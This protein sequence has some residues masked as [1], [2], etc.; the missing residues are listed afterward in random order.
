MKKKKT[1][2]AFRRTCKSSGAGLS[3]YILLEKK[4]K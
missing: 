4:V 3:H 1:I 2:I